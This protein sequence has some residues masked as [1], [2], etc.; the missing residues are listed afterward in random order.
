ML[1]GSSH[2]SEDMIVDL[3]ERHARDYDQD[4]GK[5]LQ[6]RTWLDRFLSWIPARATVLDVG[7]GSGEPIGQYVIERGFEVTGVDSSRSMIELCRE[8]FPNSEWLVADMRE[9][10][11][12]RRFGGILAWDSFF[13]LGKDAQRAMFPRLACHASRGAPLMFTS[14]SAEGESIGRLRGEP[15]YHAS[16]SPVEYERLLTAAGFVVR[17]Y[18]A[19]D[20]RCGGATVWL[21]T[22]ETN[23]A[24]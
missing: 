3:Y 17:A 11:L 8:R 2:L 1:G 4:R 24:V 14:G 23:G 10:K 20:A 5:T 21:A 22:Y 9:L 15:L 6:E 18:T 16:L 13:H 12:G 19:D 7:C